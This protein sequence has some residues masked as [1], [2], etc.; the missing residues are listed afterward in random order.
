MVGALQPLDETA[1]EG[2]MMAERVEIET[3]LNVRLHVRIGDDILASGGTRHRCTPLRYR[4]SLIER[5]FR[6]LLQPFEAHRPCDVSVQ[7]VVEGKA[8]GDP[9]QLPPDPH[10]SLSGVS[11]VYQG[12]HLPEA[13]LMFPALPFDFARPSKHG[14]RK[15][16]GR[17]DHVA[18]D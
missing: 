12:S 11:H 10:E 3:Q 18:I 15:D 4:V 16:F 13:P 2:T 8:L 9:D 17:F 14:F 5:L 6:L 1:L 7:K